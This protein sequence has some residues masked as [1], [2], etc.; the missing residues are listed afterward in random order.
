VDFDRLASW[1]DQKYPMLKRI[2][3]ANNENG[4]FANY[5]VRWDEE[6][7]DIIERYN[8]RTDFDF[9][10]ANIAVQKALKKLKDSEGNVNESTTQAD[11]NFDEWGESSKPSNS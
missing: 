11:S 9:R 10:E 4:T 5:E 6:N 1:L 2:L 8:V 7:E 3:D